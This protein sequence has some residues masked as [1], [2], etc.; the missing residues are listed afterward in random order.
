[1]IDINRITPGNVETTVTCRAKYREMCSAILR[2]G[3]GLQRDIQ[4]FDDY[5][6]QCENQRDGYGHDGWK[7]N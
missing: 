6:L 7:L 5:G 3:Y 1:M 2:D 4:Q